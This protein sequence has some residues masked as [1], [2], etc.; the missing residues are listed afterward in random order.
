MPVRT[1]ASAAL[2]GA[3]LSGDIVL[4]VLFLNPEISL[5]GESRAWLLFFPYLL[6]G[7]SVF[8]LLSLL[9]AAFRF[10]P[11]ALRPRVEGLPWF[12]SLSFLA[13]VG[14]LLG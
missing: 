2:G 4:L 6:A 9:G 10:W 5:W 11:A 1:L 8:L 14:N 12:T 7:T 3:L 13:L